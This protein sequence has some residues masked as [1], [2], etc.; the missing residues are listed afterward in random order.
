VLAIARLENQHAFAI[1]TAVCLD[2]RLWLDLLAWRPN[3][4]VQGMGVQD[5]EQN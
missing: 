4:P 1:M 5:E 2:E 3:G